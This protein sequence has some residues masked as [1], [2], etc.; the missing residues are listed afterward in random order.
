MRF[1]QLLSRVNEKLTEPLHFEKEYEALQNVRNC[2][3]HWDGYITE[4]KVD[5]ETGILRL[6]LPRPKLYFEK[7]GKEI[8]IEAGTV[9]EGDD[10]GQGVAIKFKFVPES[11][12][13]RVGEKIEFTAEQFNDIGWG[14]WA[15]ANELIGKLPKPASI[16]E[17]KA[18]LERLQGGAT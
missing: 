1:P 5:K 12:E 14:C 18:V 10:A 8:E 3:E 11:R 17:Q 15:F 6:S 2:L 4:D 13:F 9:V 7:G 16:E